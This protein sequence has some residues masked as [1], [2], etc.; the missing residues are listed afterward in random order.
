LPVQTISTFFMAIG[1]E[2]FPSLCKGE[3]RR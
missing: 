1:S 3:D 2:F